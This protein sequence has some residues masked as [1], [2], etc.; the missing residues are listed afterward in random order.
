LLPAFS[1]AREHKRMSTCS[2]FITRGLSLASGQ[3]P[4]ASCRYDS[5]PNS[6]ASLPTSRFPWVRGFG[7]HAFP[8]SYGGTIGISVLMTLLGR[9]AGYKVPSSLRIT[10]PPVRAASKFAVSISDTLCLGCSSSNV[11]ISKFP[12]FLPKGPAQLR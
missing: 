11:R 2:N 3:R 6:R 12:W 7:S 4:A 1:V 9:L 10:S 5:H 8:S